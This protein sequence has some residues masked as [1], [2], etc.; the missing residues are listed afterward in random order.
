MS[1]GWEAFL[2]TGKI[3]DYLKAK[4]QEQTDGGKRGFLADIDCRKQHN[5]LRA[6]RTRCGADE[7][8]RIM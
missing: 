5:G 4:A 8:C 3:T 2:T 7:S 6:V 1:D